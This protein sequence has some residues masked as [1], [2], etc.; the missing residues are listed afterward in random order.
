[1]TEEAVLCRF[2]IEM[3]VQNED[4]PVSSSLAQRVAAARINEA[5]H[6]VFGSATPASPLG[7]L[8]ET[9]K[10]ALAPKVAA[11]IAGAMMTYR[12]HDEAPPVQFGEL[13]L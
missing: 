2:G 8:C 11:S 9:F 6:L 4:G 13:T 1:V 3:P 12:C 7:M 5:A 10:G